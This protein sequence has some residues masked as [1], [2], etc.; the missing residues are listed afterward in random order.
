MSA[1]KKSIATRVSQPI[2][3]TSSSSDITLWL[4][5]VGLLGL[6]AYIIY[7]LKKIEEELLQT[8][9]YQ[10]QKC[11]TNEE[12]QLSFVEMEQ[13]LL[14]LLDENSRRLAMNPKS[15][16]IPSV[17]NASSRSAPNASSRSAPNAS[18]CGIP[19]VPNVSNVPNVP[20]VPN[21]S[22]IPNVSNVSNVPKN[23]VE[24]PLNTHP[25]ELKQ[26][27]PLPK[28]MAESPKEKI[29]P[30]ANFTSMMD[31]FGATIS[32]LVNSTL[33]DLESAASFVSNQAPD[34]IAVPISFNLSPIPSNIVTVNPK[35]SC[36]LEVI[37]EDDETE[38]E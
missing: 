18:T 11:V 19:N 15:F 10:K 3:H 4:A 13:K 17:P 25:T 36:T 7:R 30:S 16:C 12:F 32:S 29:P 28:E 26:S 24:S 2:S 20:N 23:P 21:V 1:S 33:H 31:N 35:E 14:Q 34:L 9:S 37:S 22:N 6:V 38:E 5:M 8:Q 27:L